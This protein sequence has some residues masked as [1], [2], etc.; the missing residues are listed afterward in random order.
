MNTE[1]KSIKIEKK[2]EIGVII[3]NMPETMNA[4]NTGM[5]QE[6]DDS[7]TQ[8]EKDEQVR[9]VII[10]GNKNFCTGANIKELKEKHP[11]E[12]EVFSR[13]GH[14]IFSQVENM[15]KP[16]IAAVNGYA[17]GAGCELALACDIRIACKNA[18][19]GQPEVN[20][21]LIPGFG[22]TQRLTRLVGIGRAKEMILTGRIIDAK[23][24]EYIGLINKV[25]GDE[26]L[27]EK[28]EEMAQVLAEKSPIAVRIAK[29]LINKNQEIKKGL[30]ME[31]VSFSECFA[32]NDH[33][34]G[35]NAFLE[36]RKPRFKGD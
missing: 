18:K 2:E 31:I 30:E 6:L 33:M 15:E 14:K 4:L 3:L 22:G 10:T 35:I 28:A 34:E 20:L 24:A 27:I 25:V 1:N 21:G 26:E 29:G 8:L 7:M 5:L 13:L 32:S 36:K 16:V 11:A 12:A 19:F 23:E 17:L 9:A